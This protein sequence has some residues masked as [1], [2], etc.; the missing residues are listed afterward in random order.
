[1]DWWSEEIA[2]IFGQNIIY[3][4]KYK[5]TERVERGTAVRLTVEERHVV[6]DLFKRDT[7]WLEENGTEDYD[8]PAG[9]ILNSITKSQT[10]LSEELQYD[11]VM[12]DEVQDF[13]RSWLLVVA[14]IPRISLCLAGDLAQKIYRRNFSGASVGIEVRGGRSRRLSNSHRTTL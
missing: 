10:G 2:W 14:K 1:M 3:L 7:E 11:H 6:W 8:N 5:E 4:N 12:V 9:K 13:G